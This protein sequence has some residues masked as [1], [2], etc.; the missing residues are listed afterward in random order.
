MPLKESFEKECDVRGEKFNDVQELLHR[1][2]DK[3]VI[4]REQSDT[5]RRLYDRFIRC[6]SL[7]E[8]YLSIL[9]ITIIHDNETGYIVVFPPQA[10][11]PQE[12]LD[13]ELEPNPLLRIRFSAL[14][15]IVLIAMRYEYQQALEKGMLL[16]NDIVEIILSEF[17]ITLHKV[18]KRTDATT[19]TIR[20]T[21]SELKRLRIIAIP[22]GFEEED[23][24]IIQ[25]RPVIIRFT[26]TS[27]YNAL[28][29][30]EESNNEKKDK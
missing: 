11:I 7:L 8:D 15:K 30:A 14:Q 26:F 24:T 17:I 6:E 29:Q 25:I 27:T 4:Y 21:F 16:E 12:T 20:E 10:I 2:L 19:S 13:N 22:P 28:K 5:E 1:L 18:F 23:D 9:D 3:Q